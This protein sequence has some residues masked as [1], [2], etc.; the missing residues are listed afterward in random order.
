MTFD[1]LLGEIKKIHC[2]E[3]RAQEADYLEVVMR[4]DTLENVLILLSSYF[5]EALKPAGI[6][7]SADALKHSGPY[8][9]IQAN[10]TMYY[11]QGERGSELA[12]LWPWGSGSSTTVKI[13]Q[14]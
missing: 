3:V 14:G 7:A 4:Q 5:G 13:I 10:Q 9:G 6:K 12:F 8:G 11:R 2:Q 1:E